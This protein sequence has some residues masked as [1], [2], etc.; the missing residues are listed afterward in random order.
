M[1]KPPKLP[2]LLDLAI[3]ANEKLIASFAI[4]KRVC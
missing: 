4:K 1:A 3:E 2:D